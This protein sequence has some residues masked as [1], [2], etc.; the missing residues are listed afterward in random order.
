[1]LYESR[2]NF[3]PESYQLISD[4]NVARTGKSTS[5]LIILGILAGAYIALAGTASTMVAFNF[6]E[7]P[8]TYGLG[9]CLAGII[10]PC[11]LVLVVLAGAELFTGNTLMLLPLAQRRIS[12]FSMLRNWGIVYPAN[13]FGA[14]ALAFLVYHSGQLTL[15]PDTKLGGVVISVAATKCN[16]TFLQAFLLGIFCNW[17]VCLAVWM[18]IS[19]KNTS[20]KILTLFLPIW[21]FV[22]AGF[23][24]SIANM[25]FI[26]VGLFAAQ[27]PELWKA[28]EAIT[29]PEV[30]ASLSWTNFFVVNLLP[31]TLGNII[32]GSFFVA[33][34]YWFV[35]RKDA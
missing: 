15:P 13:F 26:S 25:Y 28:A 12:L 19:V 23:E 11:G 18:S 20:G 21:V 24:H 10:F 34:T 32:G 5:S 1:M 22:A 6:L 4:V 30:L 27:S 16:L 3:V 29:S 14:V 31:V 2:L 17:L 7:N 35:Y 33:L 9:R 8:N